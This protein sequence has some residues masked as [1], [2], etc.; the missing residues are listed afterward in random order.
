MKQYYKEALLLILV[1]HFTGC[2]VLLNTTSADYQITT[3][4]EVVMG[5]YNFLDMTGSCNESGDD[6]GPFTAKSI[7]WRWI[8]TPDNSN[9]PEIIK[10]YGQTQITFLLES[11]GTYKIEADIEC[12]SPHY[13]D[14]VSKTVEASFEVIEKNLALVSTEILS[15]SEGEAIGDESYS[16]LQSL[17]KIYP[18]MDAWYK[19]DFNADGNEDILLYSK[20]HNDNDENETSWFITSANG[21]EMLQLDEG[22]SSINFEYMLSILG[23]QQSDEDG[24][25]FIYVLVKTDDYV[26]LLVKYELNY[27]EGSINATGTIKYSS[28]TDGYPTDAIDLDGDNSLELIVADYGDIVSI[29]SDGNTVSSYGKFITDN[30]ASVVGKKDTTGDGSDELI[31][32]IGTGYFIYRQP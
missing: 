14:S 17:Y 21:D 25:L 12:V 32:Q 29:G 7:Q 28:F 15:Q 13:G 6:G 9:Q 8:E 5:T 23:T 11:A 18:D 2:A 31:L 3:P 26:Y 20:T 30:S 19:S 4:S 24:V 27:T 16:M 22:S 1:A 10:I